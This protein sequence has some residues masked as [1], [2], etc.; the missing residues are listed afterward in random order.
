MKRL[1]MCTKSDPISKNQGATGGLPA[2]VFHVCASRTGGQAASGT[3][4]GELK[5]GCHT[6][7]QRAKCGTRFFTPVK[8]VIGL[9]LILLAA[10]AWP[11]LGCQDQSPSPNT[12]TLT[13]A[14]S[15]VPQA[16]LVEQ[17]AG[18]HAQVITLVQPGDAPET[19]QPT[20]AQVTQLMGADIYFCIGVPFE[21]GPWFNA[22][23][24]SQRLKVVDTAQNIDRRSMKR[25]RSNHP[26]TTDHSGHRHDHHDHAGQDPH[27]WLTPGLLKRQARVIADTLIAMDPSREGDYGNNLDLLIQ[28][29]DALDQAIGQELAAF[30]GRSFFVFHPAWGYFADA[31]RLRQVSIELSGQD[32]T[33][34]ELTQLQ[35][36][37][38]Q[39]GIGVI[40]VQP[41]ISSR[42]AQSVAQTIGARVEV[43]D[44]LAADVEANLLRVA[45]VLARSYR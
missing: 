41:Q 28:K 38:R 34:Y 23:I 7:A 11:S 10:V 39:E 3:P 19:Y 12:E 29:L 30:H 21:N 18:S 40:F 42:A 43:L 20:D 16:W 25:H 5:L 27:V 17:I 44:P 1:I 24:A 37:A 4:R 6:L 22:L 35:Q 45:Q 26:T 32:P 14:V 36:L 13:V 15:I 8:T 31:Y 9:R 33:D 2:S